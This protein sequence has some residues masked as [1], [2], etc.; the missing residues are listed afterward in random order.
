MLSSL[1]YFILIT[2]FLSQSC[3][4][5]KPIILELLCECASDPYKSLS[6][7]LVFLT[8]VVALSVDDLF[9]TRTDEYVSCRV[10]STA[11]LK[12]YHNKTLSLPPFIFLQRTGGLHF[13][14]LK[15]R[16]TADSREQWRKFVTPS[17][18]LPTQQYSYKGL[19]RN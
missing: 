12:I 19:D 13:F 11:N 10:A 5:C 17:Y 15:M 7:S 1:I 2:T 18:H 9:E 4:I 3:C 14:T 8:S 6:T 16:N